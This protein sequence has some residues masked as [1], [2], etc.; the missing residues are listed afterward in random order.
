MSISFTA[1]EN[2]YKACPLATLVNK[3]VYRLGPKARVIQVAFNWL[4]EFDLCP[5]RWVSPGAI[6]R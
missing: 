4:A 5:N 1:S 2:I 6:A 3:C